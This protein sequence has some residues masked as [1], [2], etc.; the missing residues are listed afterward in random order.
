[1]TKCK[2]TSNGDHTA[3]KEPVHSHRNPLLRASGGFQWVLRNGAAQPELCISVCRQPRPHPRCVHVCSAGHRSALLV[4]SVL[5]NWQVGHCLR[6]LLTWRSPGQGGWV[7]GVI[8][9]TRQ[10]FT[11]SWVS[12]FVF[13]GCFVQ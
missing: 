7:V 6:A 8:L 12:V 4:G 5:G 1:M 2:A 9:F 13:H 10:L 3:A 11:P